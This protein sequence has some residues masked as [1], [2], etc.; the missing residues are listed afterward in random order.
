MPAPPPLP[1]SEEETR[2]RHHVERL[3]V[4][5]KFPAVG[6][7]E[8]HAKLKDRI[9]T[10]LEKLTGYQDHVRSFGQ[11]KTILGPTGASYLLRP[12]SKEIVRHVESRRYRPLHDVRSEQRTYE[13]RLTRFESAIGLTDPPPKTETVYILEDDRNQG[14]E[15]YVHLSISSDGSLCPQRGFSSICC[16]FS[17]GPV[18]MVALR[19][20]ARRT[21]PM[22]N[23]R[24]SSDSV[25]LDLMRLTRTESVAFW[26]K[27]QCGAQRGIQQRSYASPEA[28]GGR[29]RT[30]EGERENGKR[31][32]EGDRDEADRYRSRRCVRRG[33]PLLRPRPDTASID[34]R[35]RCGES[36][37]P[38][39]F[40][41][42]M[43]SCSA[44]AVG[45]RPSGAS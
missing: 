29:K 43:C 11:A 19:S 39:L 5:K 18:S 12:F 44:R 24:S 23:G 40:G 27:E 36:P 22:R 31:T 10:V 2:G 25:L 17:F 26:Y 42:R 41:F 38:R 35:G 21:P 16:R 32:D 28:S 34:P 3:A 9:N 13:P 45:R 1:P 33:A 30:V 20:K 6:S 7:K 15:P 37:R 4:L 8:H 14:P